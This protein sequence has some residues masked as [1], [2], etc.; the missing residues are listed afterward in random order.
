[1]L[2]GINRTTGE[3]LLRRMGSI[4]AVFS[5][6]QIELNAVL[7]QRTGQLVATAR[8]G[9]LARA[10]QEEV[11]LQ[12]SDVRAR[13]FSDSDYPTRL[14]ECED[15][16]AMVYTLGDTDINKMRAIA[17][18]GTRHCSA[19]GVD[20]V[21]RLVAGLKENYGENIAIISGLAYGI[22]V[23]AHNAALNAGLPTVAVMANPLNTVYPAEHRDVARR[24]VRSGGMLMSEYP[25]GTRI[26]RGFFLAR[27]RII[28]GLSDA[29]VVVESDIR[30]GAMATARLAAAYN[31]E[32]FAVPGRVSDACS[33]GCLELI[34]RREALIVRDA[35]DIGD[36]LGWAPTP[37][38]GEQK[39]LLLELSPEQTR[40]VEH[41]RA[42]PEHTVN[43]IC[44]ALGMPYAS[45]S[46]MLF[47]L[48][49]ADVVVT[50][51]G[52]RYGL[53]NY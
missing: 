46:S 19:Y 50:L 1:M 52:G 9:A 3:E 31:R 5:A 49:M 47:E 14:L 12:T 38:E 48:E 33:R 27:N 35:A 13:F 43:D 37:R 10:I 40:V 26:H 15:G 21:N 22:D 17:I 24:I 28:A 53:L 32:L 2:N 8:S 39:E 44:V 45:L 36:A 30:G 11:F 23:A 4:D 20:F 16:P 41:I 25:T 51:P 6:T 7:G 34:A 29:V 42:N 18:V